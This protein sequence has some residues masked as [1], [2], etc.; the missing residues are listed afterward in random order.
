MPFRYKHV[1]KQWVP[2]GLPPINIDFCVGERI[3]HI[4]PSSLHGLGF[5]SMDGIKVSYNKVVELVRYVGP[6]YNYKN[7]MRIVQ[8]KKSMHRYALSA[9]YLQW[10]ENDQSKRLAV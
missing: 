7:W 10:K 3:Y 9:N 1:Q 4:A 6:C 2:N 8:Y 5:F